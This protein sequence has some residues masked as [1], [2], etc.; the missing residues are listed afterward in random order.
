MLF[1]LF[2]GL[3]IGCWWGSRWLLFPYFWTSTF[4]I[5]IA[6]FVFVSS[7]WVTFRN[8]PPYFMPKWK[9]YLQICKL[10]SMQV[11]N[12]ISTLATDLM[13]K[14]WN[15]RVLQDSDHRNYPHPLFQRTAGLSLDPLC[16]SIRSTLPAHQLS[17][18][19][20]CSCQIPDANNIIDSMQR[21][22]KGFLIFLAEN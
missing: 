20:P 17:L 19:Y 9:I 6:G 4:P 18:I 13:R 14:T 21:Q 2:F 11:N 12:Q 15:R 7:L 10:I 22:K 1:L 5:L 8:V 16:I 3:L